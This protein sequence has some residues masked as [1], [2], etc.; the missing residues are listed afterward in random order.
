VDVGLEDVDESSPMLVQRGEDTVDVALRVHDDRY[1]TV[2][3]QVAAVAE[4]GGLDDLNVSVAGVRSG[5]IGWHQEFSR[6]VIGTRVPPA[7][8]PSSLC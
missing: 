7:N 2:G 1:L 4:A 5:G 6:D 3:D 8:Q